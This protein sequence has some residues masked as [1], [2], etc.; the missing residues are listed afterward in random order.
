MIVI[1]TFLSANNMY[2]HSSHFFLLTLKSLYISSKKVYY[3]LYS[4]ENPIGKYHAF[5][6]VV[7]A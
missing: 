1:G 4:S 3:E 2:T 6:S 7:W 5:D